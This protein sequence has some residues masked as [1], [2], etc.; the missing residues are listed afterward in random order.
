MT[1]KKDAVEEVVEE[2]KAAA[3]PAAKKTTA[4]KKVEEKNEVQVVDKETGEILSSGSADDLARQ[5]L[6]FL[7]EF[8]SADELSALTG[9]DNI[10]SSDI[11]IPYAYLIAKDGKD[12]S[13]GDIVLPNGDVIKGWGDGKDAPNR[14]ENVTIFKHPTGTR[15]LPD[16]IQTIE[17]I[18][19]SFNRWETWCARW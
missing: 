18:H 12:V 8:F 2:T 15:I 4:A 10:E 7:D 17:L 13:K 19:L 16:T 6:D 14:M 11:S 5:D 1:E 9:I 3:K